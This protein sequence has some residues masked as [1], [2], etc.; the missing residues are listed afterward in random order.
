MWEIVQI[1]IPSGSGGILSYLGN[2]TSVDL[3][4]PSVWKRDI[5][6]KVPVRMYYPTNMTKEETLPV[7]IYF[8]GGGFVFISNDD[9]FFD[10]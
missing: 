2:V 10:W 4:I 1:K 6:Y 8:H 7:L 3:E 9:I 5:N